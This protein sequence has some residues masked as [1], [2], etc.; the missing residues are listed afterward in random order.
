MIAGQ[1]RISRLEQEKEQLILDFHLLKVRHEKEAKVYVLFVVYHNYA[2]DQILYFQLYMKIMTIG[3]Y[4]YLVVHVDDI[5]ICLCAF[6]CTFM[7][8]A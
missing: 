3:S 8:I 1:E 7:H 2:H 6:I 4:L 5:Y